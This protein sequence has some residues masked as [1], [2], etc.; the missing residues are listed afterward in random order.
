MA[1]QEWSD[2][3]LI[4]ALRDRAALRGSTFSVRQLGG[5]EWLA[6]MEQQ[7]PIGVSIIQSGQGVDKHAT[8][9]ALLQA[10]DFAN[11]LE[12]RGAPRLGA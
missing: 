6:A 8:L 9:V 7:T 1:Y 10:D 3:Q 11:G 4:D 12:R 5:G 2:D